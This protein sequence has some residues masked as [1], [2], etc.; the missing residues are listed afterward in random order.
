M[1]KKDTKQIK[2]LLL[3]TGGTRG[4]G[5]ALACLSV[6]D[7]RLALVYHRN[8]EAAHALQDR[9]FANHKKVR[10]EEVQVYASDLS[11]P[12]QVKKVFAQVR[13]EMGPV[14]YL[15][16]N[17]AKIGEIA[18]FDKI[19]LRRFQKTFST[20]C[21]SVISCIK[22][23]LHQMRE[24]PRKQDKCIINISSGAVRTGAPHEYIDY[25]MSKGALE[26]LTFGLARELVVDNIRVNGVRPGVIDTDIHPNKETRIQTKVPI[27]PMGRIGK[28]EEVAEGILWLL[29]RKASYVTATFLD[30]AGGK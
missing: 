12:L 13:K 20:N 25:S 14:S 30:I 26:S 11:K 24:H 28:A 29:S 9:I 8:H 2:P 10:K 5:A 15:V 18:N 7:Y 19:S 17:V 21:Y 27:I 3:I 4:I 22:E 6:K 1:K 23:A 16:N